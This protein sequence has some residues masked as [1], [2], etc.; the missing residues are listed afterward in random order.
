MAPLELTKSLP[1][2]SMITV[3]SGL[4]R[5]GSEAPHGHQHGEVLA[6]HK[7]SIDVLAIWTALR[8]SQPRHSAG[9]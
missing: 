2:P 6:L 9:L 8:F 7:A 1:E 3:V 5:S 4:P